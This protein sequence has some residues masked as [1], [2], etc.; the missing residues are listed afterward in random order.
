MERQIKINSMAD[1]QSII[2][3]ATDCVDMIEV[4]DS[5]GAIVD[6]KSILGLMSLDCSAPVSLVGGNA[7]EV[8]RVY[9]TFCSRIQSAA[10]KV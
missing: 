3:A 9:A 10:S 5:R 4:A 8:E 1:I 2:F 7:D 6:A